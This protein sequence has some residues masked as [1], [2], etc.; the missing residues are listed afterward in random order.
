MSAW[1]SGVLAA[2]LMAGF[3]AAAPAGAASPLRVCLDQN[4]SLLSSKRGEEAL[5]F[6]LLVTQAVAKRLGRP[7]ELQWFETELDDQSNPVLEANALLSDRR[8]HLIAG[9]ALFA[10]AIGAPSA[11]RSRL[12]SFEGA[13]PEDRRRWVALNAVEASRGYSHSPLVVVVG[14]Q[15]AGRRIENLADLKG[16]ALGAEETTLGGAILMSYRG[17]MLRNQITNVSPGK[18]V[19][20]GIERGEYGATLVELNRFDAYVAEHPE[21]KL[22]S[23]GHYHSLG[24]NVGFLGLAS[25]AALISEVNLAIG[26]MLEGSDLQSLAAAVGLTYLPPRQPDT[27]PA[28][29]PMQLRVD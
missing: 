1:R 14:P 16:L 2:V 19:L 15:A 7:L 5:G 4:A 23:S 10:T 24:H 12:P 17:G 26:E 21:T 22:S 3:A 11:E 9:Y 18:G 8:C 28:I 6:D 27:L 20:E 29:S 25:D 13:K